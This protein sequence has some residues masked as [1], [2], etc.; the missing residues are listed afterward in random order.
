MAERLRAAERQGRLTALGVV[1]GT[2]LA[3]ALA[4]LVNLLL[5]S[6]AAA[7]ETAA[8]RLAQQNDLL[9]S[10]AVELE[11]MNEQ[12]T[13]QAAELESQTEQ[14][15]QNAIE[16]ELQ[17]DE[18]QQA[19]EELVQRT[20]VAEEAN[21]AKVSFLRAM[22][23]ELRTPLNAIGGYAELLELGIRGPLTDAQRQDLGRIVGSQRHLLSLI[24]DILNFAK[25]EAGRVH[26]EIR[27]CS[28]GEILAG[29]EAL[30]L[31]QIELKGQT[32][33]WAAGDQDLALNADSERVRQILLNLLSNAIKFTPQGGR[34]AVTV[35]PNAESIGIQVTDT[36]IG[37]PADRLSSIFE[38]FVQVH[39]TLSEAN[40]GTGLGLAIRRELARAMLGDLTVESEPGHGST[41]A[42]ELPRAVIVNA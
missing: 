34:I 19:T 16:L 35:T 27:P 14:L 20:E 13:E 28:V 2:L 37:I 15:Q 22:S 18:L 11:L 26:F 5:A 9:Q 42:L 23:H 6:Y 7:Q 36:G 17:R 40:E 24:N 41:F 3:G 4:L 1:V 12:L 10:Q 32:Y 30:V 25:L 8:R 39:R 21:R 31:P 33:T 29:I 38:P